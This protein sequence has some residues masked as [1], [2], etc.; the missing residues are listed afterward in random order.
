[1]KIVSRGPFFRWLAVFIPSLFFGLFSFA[2]ASVLSFVGEVF[3]SIKTGGELV[4][5]KKGVTNSQNIEL[6]KPAL[7]RDP[8][9]A[10][11]GG[12]VTIVD[13]SALL[14][15]NAL[16]HD[17]TEIDQAP[18]GQISVYVVRTGD[19]L[20]QIAKMF[21]VSSNTIRWAN[22]ISSGKGVS[23]GQKLVILPVNG[24]RY[25][26]KKGDT[27]EKIAQ[28]HKAVKDEIIEFND[29]EGKDIV[30]GDILLIPNGLM[31][32]PAAS[33]PST[34]PITSHIAHAV[35][36]PVVITGATQD[37]SG[38]F[39]YPAPGTRKT[40]GL[41]GYNGVD[42]GGPIGTTVLAAA[43]GEVL[44]SRDSGWNG[45][46]GQYIVIKHGN[47]M[48][49]LYGHL[50]QTLVSAGQTVTKGQ[51][52]GAIG[53]TGRSTGPHLHFE[54]RGGRNPF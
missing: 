6:L 2:H 1:M 17:K 16:S 29:L 28:S 25:T 42:L 51:P 41:H 37:S 31:D 21:G 32:T 54:V 24:I 36:T 46:Y 9:P 3:Q 45:G 30:V 48:Q 5:E 35:S 33:S 13:G 44:I 22:D 47:G 38:Y 49:T 12:E 50:S 23:V 52:I 14:A 53:N 18:N 4:Y 26:V 40:Q 19:T 27:L 34:S 8:S 10:R 7:N 20:S 15:D 39:T 43:D 11:G